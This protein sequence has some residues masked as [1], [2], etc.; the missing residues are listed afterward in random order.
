VSEPK[1]KC[2]ATNRRGE[3]CQAPPMKDGELC[4]LHAGKVEY[5]DFTD[6]EVRAR[7]AKRRD[8]RGRLAEDA[9]D[10][11][12]EKIKRTLDDALNAETTRSALCECGRRVSVTFNDVNA[13]LKAVQLWLEQGYGK[14][15]ETKTLDVDSGL[16]IDSMSREE[17]E[18]LKREL[19]AQYPQLRAVAGGRRE[20]APIEAEPWQDRRPEGV[21]RGD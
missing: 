15:K 16:D 13:R 19:L 5:P 6:P 21:R 12:E 17:R 20:R 18:A 2:T 10:E 14:P 4:N 11:Y 1:R 8:V 7:H 3:P 9:A